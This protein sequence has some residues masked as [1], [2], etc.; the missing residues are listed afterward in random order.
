[1]ASLSLEQE[2]ETAPQ[3][4][5]FGCEPSKFPKT[6]LPTKKR[7]LL[8]YQLVRFQMQTKINKEPKTNDVAKAVA[9]KVM[10]LWFF[11]SLPT[12]K[13][14]SIVKE[15]C[16]LYDHKGKCKLT[17]NTQNETSNKPDCYIEI[18]RLKNDNEIVPESGSNI[19]RIEKYLKDSELLFDIY[20]CR[21]EKICSSSTCK[22]CPAVLFE[23]KDF[24][25]DQRSLRELYFDFQIDIRGTRY[26]DEDLKYYFR[27]HKSGKDKEAQLDVGNQNEEENPIF[28]KDASLR[29]LA[30]A[31][32][33]YSTS[34]EQTACLANSLI[35]CLKPHL[36]EDSPLND[37]RVT[38]SDI[39]DAKAKLQE[40]MSKTSK[41]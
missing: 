8:Y 39:Q 41:K 29:N 36:S 21:N 38:P 9:K 23:D 14:N 40:D 37:F 17:T 15:I 5:V 30:I 31:S 6:Q 19:E 24:L 18:L 27:S 32:D 25:S 10:K 1:M 35:K 13:L 26:L 12:I 22:V 16:V 20:R 28:S 34:C 2:K 33:L 11:A 7:V 3:C 4:P